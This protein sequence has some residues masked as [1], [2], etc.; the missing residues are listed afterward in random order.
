[1]AVLLAEEYEKRFPEAIHC[2][3]DGLED[4]L[5]FYHFPEIEKIGA[6]TG[7]IPTNK[8]SSRHWSTTRNSCQLKELTEG[9]YGG[10][11]FANKS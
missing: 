2:L 1:M 10:F 8:R 7:A 6:R 9:V 5:Q 3:E 11:Q 4:S